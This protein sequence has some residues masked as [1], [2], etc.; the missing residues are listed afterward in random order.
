MAIVNTHRYLA[1]RD[2]I[3][4]TSGSRPELL[5]LVFRR[6]PV[7]EGRIGELRGKRIQ[8]ARV[9]PL[10]WAG[11]HEEKITTDAGVYFRPEEA[12]FD[13]EKLD[14]LERRCRG[15]VGEIPPAVR[16][17][18]GMWM[19]TPRVSAGCLEWLAAVFAE[20]A[21]VDRS[22]GIEFAREVIAQHR[23]ALAAKAA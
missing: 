8:R 11:I 20:I 23:Q 13:V 9:V 19:Q 2:A 17:S 6:G 18:F 1:Y 16:L 14:Q 22:R 4:S 7:V 5:A 3:L 10:V 15:I 21:E 12:W